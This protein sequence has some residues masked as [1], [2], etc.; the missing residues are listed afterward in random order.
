[1]RKFLVLLLAAGF[2]ISLTGCPTDGS[3]GGGEDNT[4]DYTNYTTN[5]AIRIKNESGINLVA[6]RGPPSPGNLMGGVPANF[7]VHGLRKDL[8]LFP[9]TG[10]SFDYVLHLITEE[11]YLANRD[12]LPTLESRSF[13]KLW[14]YHNVGSPNESVLTVSN[15]LG[16]T[17]KIKV[18]NATAYNVELRQGS[19]HTGAI[20]GYVGAETYDSTEFNVA[21]QAYSVF[22]I[23]RKFDP[24]LGIIKSAYPKYKPGHELA[25]LAIGRRFQ[26]GT[27]TEATIN[28]QQFLVDTEFAAGYAFLYVQNNVSDGIT[29]RYGIEDVLTQAGEMIVN[30]GHSL[31]FPIY[32]DRVLGKDDEYLPYRDVGQLSIYSFVTRAIPEFRFEEGKI[33]R[34]NVSGTGGSFTLSEI[35]Y[36][37]D[38]SF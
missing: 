16:G 22:P 23:F 20:I 8:S 25:G 5:Y 37:R 3:N 30:P 31:Y 2:V 29:L 10:S 1:M 6:F 38:W 33:Y 15:F 36:E 9:N 4:I 7:T 34:I 27:T 21:P 17:H 24:I 35:T 32:M 12:K 26:L 11:D 19:V 13:T 18:N 28:V 14:A